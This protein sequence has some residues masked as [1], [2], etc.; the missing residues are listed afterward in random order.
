[1]RAVG[2][3]H[4]GSIDDLRLAQLEK[5]TVGEHD[6]LV[7]VHA[8]SVHPEVWHVVSGRPYV[9][10]L[11]GSGSKPKNPIP[12]TDLAGVVEAVGESCSSILVAFGRAQTSL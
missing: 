3:D 12:G 2:Q 10:R 9:L 11:M 4:C 5:P 8:S 7:R 1:M 6:V